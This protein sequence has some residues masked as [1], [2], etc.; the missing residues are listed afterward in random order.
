MITIYNIK[1]NDI[2]NNKPYI[3]CELRG[4]STDTKVTQIEE[5]IIE[6]GS[7]FI[8]IDTQDVFIYDGENETWLP[9]VENNAE[10]NNDEDNELN[11][12][13]RN[14]DNELN[15]DIRNLDN[16]IN[17]I[18]NNEIEDNENR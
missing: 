9:E 18:E 6:N 8:E 11:A 2:I 15:V 14:L 17:E 4:L 3:L 10:E 12:N 16:E 1:R 7:V 13:I 5:N